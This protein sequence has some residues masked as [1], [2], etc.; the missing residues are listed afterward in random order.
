MSAIDEA[1][2]SSDGNAIFT[3]SYDRILRT[4][5]IGANIFDSTTPRNLKPY[6]QVNVG[7]PIHA[8]A[9]NPLFN[10]NSPET[11][12]ALVSV[13]N[14]YI[15][16]YNTIYPSANSAND[17]S[18]PHDTSQKLAR[19]RWVNQLTEEVLSA[20]SL[21]Y[22]PSG[23]HFLAGGQ[24]EIVLFDLN[25]EDKPA[26]AIQTTPFKKAKG[27]ARGYKGVVTSLSMSPSQADSNTGILA[28]GTR[29]RHISLYDLQGNGDQI[30]H[31]QLPDKVHG[32]TNADTEHVGSIT[33]NGVTMLKWSP[34]ATYLYI[35][36][37][38]SD[39]ILVY[40]VRN[41]RHHLGYCAGR[42]ADTN[43]KM[44]FDIWNA[45]GENGNHEIWAGGTDG[46]IRVWRDPHLKEGALVPDED[47]GV[48][49][50]P[51]TSVLAH[52]YGTLAI[53]AMGSEVGDE[54]ESGK[55]WGGD[56]VRPRYRE[57]GRLDIIGVG[58][59]TVGSEGV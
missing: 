40:D 51:V 14:Q 20:S 42:K 9:S 18:G 56:G 8:F 45:G 12:H 53:A 6:A 19:Y 46:R 15:S 41:F 13:K 23:T 27:N 44:G 43:R 21:I 28:A 1:F 2:L 52:P 57:R 29:T 32:H 34:C 50:M 58:F 54:D 11:T 25:R 3:K 22:T 26:W 7:L 30:T 31:F 16:L 5:G 59:D 24:N 36:E 33:G 35:A 17:A 37:R 10:L 4:Y 39:V 47:I 38:R 48:A 55:L 49:D